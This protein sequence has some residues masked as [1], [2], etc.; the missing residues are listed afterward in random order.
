MEY[1][2]WLKLFLL[3]LSRDAT[4]EENYKQILDDLKAAAPLLSKDV[5]VTATNR[6]F[7]YY[8]NLALQARVYLYMGDNVNALKAAEEI[9]KSTEIYPVY[10]CQ[11]GKLMEIAS[12]VMN[13]YWNLV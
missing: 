10:Q 1:P 8:A 12:L 9:I 7:N 2:M 13:L 5:R 11:L 4:V 6:Y 3:Q